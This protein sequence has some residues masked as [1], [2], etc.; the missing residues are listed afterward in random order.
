M[1][2]VATYALTLRRATDTCG[3]SRWVLRPD[4]EP[5]TGEE[6]VTWLDYSTCAH[7]DRCFATAAHALGT[8]LARTGCARR[9]PFV[10]RA[11]IKS[12]LARVAAAA[13]TQVVDEE[14]REAV[15]QTPASPARG[16]ARQTGDRA[17]QTEPS[18]WI[19]QRI[20]STQ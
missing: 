14:K 5:R 8:R 4:A 3:A 12:T 19:T 9:V 17:P 18:A 15:R 2:D 1:Q 20:S 13:L 6:V 10:P 7:R 11:V 16:R